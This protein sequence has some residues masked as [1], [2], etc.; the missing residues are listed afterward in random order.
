MKIDTANQV[1]IALCEAAA[2]RWAARDLRSADR[3]FT[4]AVQLCEVREF[5]DLDEATR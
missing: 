3:I 2:A 1:V 4:A 5:I